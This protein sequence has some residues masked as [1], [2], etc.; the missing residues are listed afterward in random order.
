MSTP[1]RTTIDKNKAVQKNDKGEIYQTPQLTKISTLTRHQTDYNVPNIQRG[2]ALTLEYNNIQVVGNTMADSVQQHI[3]MCMGNDASG[4]ARAG[5]LACNAQLA[6]LLVKPELL[7]IRPISTPDFQ[8]TAANL[9]APT[10]GSL[11]LIPCMNL[12]DIQRQGKLASEYFAKELSFSNIWRQK[13]A[14]KMNAE[15][16]KKQNSIT[17]KELVKVYGEQFTEFSWGIKLKSTV[18]AYEAYRSAESTKTIKDAI[19]AFLEHNEARIGF[20]RNL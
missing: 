19:Q 4:E 10:S 15:F 11:T 20:S 16:V 1:T 5:I 6:A 8:A 9:N 3:H 18:I 14:I 2:E 7:D 12:D 13:E 17:K